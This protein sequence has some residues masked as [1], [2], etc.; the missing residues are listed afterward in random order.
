LCPVM[1]RPTAPSRQPR[2]AS[3][4]PRSAGDRLDRGDGNLLKPSGN[5]PLAWNIL[6]RMAS[7]AACAGLVAEQR[8]IRRMQCPA[9]SA[10]SRSSM[11][12]TPSR[13]SSPNWAGACLLAR[14]TRPSGEN[15]LQAADGSSTGQR[16]ALY[17]RIS[18]ADQSCAAR[19]G[20]HALPSAPATGGR[21]LQKPP[22]SGSSRPAERRRSMATS[23][24]HAGSMQCW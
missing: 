23:R 16:A 22:R 9:S 15:G 11:V 17:C 6:S 1:R 5:R 14:W 8:A 10:S 12:V 2:Q 24:R 4:A 13:F 7:P 21:R 20:P 19:N 18:T 3:A